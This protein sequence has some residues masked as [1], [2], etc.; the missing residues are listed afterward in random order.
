MGTKEHRRSN[1]V[2]RET[3]TAEVQMFLLFGFLAVLIVIMIVAIV[4][5]KWWW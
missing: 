3:M 1:K 4:R 5:N 2:R